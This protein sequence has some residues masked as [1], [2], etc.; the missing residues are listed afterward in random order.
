MVTKRIQRGLV[1]GDLPAAETFWLEL[2]LELLLLFGLQEALILLLLDLL[3]LVRAHV[4]DEL[5]VY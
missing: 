1:P 5:L 4:G 2:A 3:L